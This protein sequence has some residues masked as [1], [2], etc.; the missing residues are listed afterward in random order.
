MLLVFVYVILS[1]TLLDHKFGILASRIA[2][3]APSVSCFGARLVDRCL[4]QCFRAVRAAY[5]VHL[6]DTK[7]HR[8]HYGPASVCR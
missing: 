8:L 2:R 5:S 6:G 3:P 1:V 4:P 7:L